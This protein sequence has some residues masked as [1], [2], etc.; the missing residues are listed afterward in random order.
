MEQ[1]HQDSKRAEAAKKEQKVLILRAQ[2][3]YLKDR[4]ARYQEN[5]EYERLSYSRFK[6]SKGGKDPVTLAS[7]FEVYE[8]AVENIYGE[9]GRIGEREASINQQLAELK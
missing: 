1:R 2:S 6:A 9:L 7:V 5:L 8:K 3:E 4:R